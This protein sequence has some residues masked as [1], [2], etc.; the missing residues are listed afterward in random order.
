M[1]FERKNL[2]LKRLNEYPRYDDNAEIPVNA[3][4]SQNKVINFLDQGF[5]K[6]IMYNNQTIYYENKMDFDFNFY[7]YFS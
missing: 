5:L 3:S 2:K 6:L 1:T 4:I 7:Y